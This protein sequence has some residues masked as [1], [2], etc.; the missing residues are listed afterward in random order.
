V[1]FLKGQTR[2]DEFAFVLLAGIALIIILAVAYST[3]QQ[4]PIYASLSTSNLQIAQGTSASVTLSLNGTGY[5]VT[6][7]GDGTIENWINF[8]ENNFDLPGG[9]KEITVTVLVPRDADFRTYTG[10]I[11]ILSGDKTYKVPLTVDVTLVTVSEVPRTIRLGDFTVSHVVGTDIIG[12]K[13]DVEVAKGYFADFST[14][15]TAT[16]PDDKMNILTD[17]FIQIFVENSNSAGNLFVELNGERIYAN[18]IS[19]GEILIPLGV[20][21]IHKYNSVVLHADNP[22]FQ[23]WTNT[24]YKIKFIKFEINFNGISSKQKTFTLDANDLNNF[25]YG[26][27]SFQVKNY[28]PQALNPMLIQINGATFYDDIPTLTYF[29]KNFGTEIPLIAGENTISFSV[30]EESNYQLASVAI[31]IVH[32]I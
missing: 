15:F 25:G 16:V 17:G 21:A 18:T 9:T 28:D 22:G 12:E 11:L 2:I 26:K 32:H 27:V 5:N 19:T 31:T 14:S 13:D 23:F 8:D 3:I 20:S 7:S 1:Y 4:G 6:L 29:S 24:N 30:S 10:D